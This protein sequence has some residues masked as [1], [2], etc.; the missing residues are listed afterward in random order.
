MEPR[1]THLD[2]RDPGKAGVTD[3]REEVDREID[4]YGDK[5]EGLVLLAPEDRWDEF[6][7]LSGAPADAETAIYRGVVVKRAA[8]TAVVAQEG[9]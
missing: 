4:A 7:R 1:P 5:T 3:I 8:V 6:V 2:T 9:F